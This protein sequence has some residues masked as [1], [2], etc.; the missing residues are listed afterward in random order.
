VDPSSIALKDHG[1]IMK[2]PDV[3][4]KDQKVPL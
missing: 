4:E 2:L 1:E 3:D